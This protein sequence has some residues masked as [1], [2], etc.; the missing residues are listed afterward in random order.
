MSPTSSESTKRVP[1]S[2]FV[3]VSE[4]DDAFVDPSAG[5]GLL[6]LAGKVLRLR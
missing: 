4:A 6:C 2:D 3:E 5:L 1:F